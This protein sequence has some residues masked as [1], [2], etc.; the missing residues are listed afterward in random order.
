MFST[1]F[2]RFRQG[3]PNV[4]VGLVE[5]TV[6]EISEQI[7]GGRVDLGFLPRIA[8]K[9][10][11]LSTLNMLAKGGYGLAFVPRFYVDETQEAV[12]LRTT[13]CAEWELVAA[14]HQDHYVTRAEE[15]MIR[16]ATDYYLGKLPE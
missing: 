6:L 7:A 11:S 16:L 3:C 10:D 12:Y 1:I 5:G 8:F 13:P 4:K 9:T 15:D 14:Y 2:P